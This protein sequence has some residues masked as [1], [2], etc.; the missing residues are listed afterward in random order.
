MIKQDSQSSGLDHCN[1]WNLLVSVVPDLL[2]FLQGS[3]GIHLCLWLGEFVFG[4]C[5]FLQSCELYYMVLYGVFCEGYVMLLQ[6][7]AL[8]YLDMHICTCAHANLHTKPPTHKAHTPVNH[9]W[10]SPPLRIRWSGSEMSAKKEKS[11]ALLQIHKMF[12]SGA[13]LCAL[14]W[15]LSCYNINTIFTFSTK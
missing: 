9:E 4:I 2:C 8:I 14:T 1:L 10:G 11:A 3:W 13:Q 15:Q 6:L 5:R 7:D 12:S